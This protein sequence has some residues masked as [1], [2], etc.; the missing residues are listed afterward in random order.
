MIT[1]TFI[2]G[3]EPAQVYERSWDRVLELPWYQQ[4]VFYGVPKAGERMPED[5]S[6]WTPVQESWEI[7]DEVKE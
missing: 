3:T 7:K 4:R 6:D 1:E 5:V 2:A